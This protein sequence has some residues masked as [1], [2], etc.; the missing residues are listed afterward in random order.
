MVNTYKK[1]PSPIRC[2]VC[3]EHQNL[4]GVTQSR[5]LIPVMYVSK[6]QLYWWNG[7]VLRKC[8][9]CCML[10]K[11]LN[12]GYYITRDFHACFAW[13]SENKCIMG[14]F[15]SI[16]CLISR[17]FNRFEWSLIVGFT[18]KSC[19]VN[20]ILAYINLPQFLLYMNFK[21]LKQLIILNFEIIRKGLK[22]TCL[23]L[24]PYSLSQ[25]VQSLFQSKFFESAV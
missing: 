3:A 2:W 21:T 7:K 5:N 17:I 10:E 19:Q 12:F 11:N 23:L 16:L 15:L 22:Y 6:W 24:P 1:H 20:L 18:I 9:I 4:S 25:Q 14:M 13:T 8:I